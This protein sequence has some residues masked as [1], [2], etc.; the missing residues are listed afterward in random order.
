MNELNQH[1]RSD[2]I[3]W[4]FTGAA[5]LLIFVMLAGICLQVFGNGKIKPSEW[6]KKTDTEQSQTALGN[7]VISE[8]ESNGIEL[9]SAEVPAEEYANYGIDPLTTKNVFQLSVTYVPA[10]TTYQQTDYEIKFANPNS[11]WAT[12]KNITDYADLQH[13]AGSKNAVLTIKKAFSE[14]IIVTA[15]SQRDRTKWV[16]FTVDYVCSDFNIRLETTQIDIDGDICVGDYSCVNGTLPI[17]YINNVTFVVDVGSFVSVMADY[18]FTIDRYWSY[19][20]MQ[21][22]DFN[23]GGLCCIIDIWR[24]VGHYSTLSVERR[25][26]YDNALALIFG[27]YSDGD[28]LFSYAFVYNRVYNGVDYGG[29]NTG[30]YADYDWGDIEGKNFSVLEVKAN[31]LTT[32]NSHIVAG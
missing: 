32:N 26:E 11:Q 20:L 28:G 5:F 3:K 13:E 24:N 25:Q 14:R 18:G 12:G 31:S 16:N 17:D 9:C 10:H 22:D 8:I 27:N 23:G 21:E 2:K 1:K 29:T 4:I 15:R 19:T 7:T 30:N 6:G